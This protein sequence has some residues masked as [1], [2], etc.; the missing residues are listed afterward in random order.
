MTRVS[1]VIGKVA[2]MIARYVRMLITVDKSIKARLKSFVDEVR[3]GSTSKRGNAN[4]RRQG[5]KPIF[6]GLSH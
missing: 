3:T 1:P 5:E 6:V 4:P 2:D